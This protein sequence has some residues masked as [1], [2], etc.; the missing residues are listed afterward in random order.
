MF[1]SDKS[2]KHAS[3]YVSSCLIQRKE[4][5]IT[6]GTHRNITNTLLTLCNYFFLIELD[7]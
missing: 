6:E 7:S 4:K 5:E 3:S 1:P 2:T